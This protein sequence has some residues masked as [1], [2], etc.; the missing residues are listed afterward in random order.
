MHANF[1]VFFRWVWNATLLDLENILKILHC[2]FDL[3]FFKYISYLCTPI[4]N[5]HSRSDGLK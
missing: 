1:F 5:T 2:E 3:S 4:S